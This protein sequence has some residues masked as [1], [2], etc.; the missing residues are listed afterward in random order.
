MG[1]YNL[2]AMS[3]LGVSVG[4]RIRI[5]AG[6]HAGKGGVVASTR[7]AHV[8]GWVMVQL[9]NIIQASPSTGTG[10]PADRVGISLTD[11]DISECR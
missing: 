4:D 7:G 8:S 9:D 3:D 2:R 10:H 1:N 5:R 6:R 11:L